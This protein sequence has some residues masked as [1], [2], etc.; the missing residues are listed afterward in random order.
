MYTEHNAHTAYS[1][2]KVHCV[3]YTLVPPLRLLGPLRLTVLLLSS[4]CFLWASWESLLSFSIWICLSAI[5]ASS[6]LNFHR[7]GST[8]NTWNAVYMTPHVRAVAASSLKVQRGP[9]KDM[10]SPPN[11]EPDP[12]P[13]PKNSDPMSPITEAMVVGVEISSLSSPSP[14]TSLRKSS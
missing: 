10:S 3:H 5:L 14:R 11:S 9:M 2:V 12:F 13:I 4:S 8:I 1:T 7:L 6:F